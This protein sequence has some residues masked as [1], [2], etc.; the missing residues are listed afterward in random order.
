MC[1]SQLRHGL[2]TIN[3]HDNLD[4][5]PSSTTAKDAIHGTGISLL[6]FPIDLMLGNSRT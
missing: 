6:Q 3:T 5:N 2:L 4:H 1:P